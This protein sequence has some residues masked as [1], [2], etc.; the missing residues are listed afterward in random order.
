LH[1]ISVQV[2][3]NSIVK[4]K[5]NSIKISIN[6]LELSSNNLKYG[7]NWTLHHSV[8]SLM[9]KANEH[10]GSSFGCD[11]SQRHHVFEGSW[12]CSIPRPTQDH[13]AMVL[14]GSTKGSMESGAFD[15]NN[16]SFV[17]LRLTLSNYW[18][19]W[20]LQANLEPII[21]EKERSWLEIKSTC[22]KSESTWLFCATSHYGP[23]PSLI[24]VNLPCFFAWLS[25]FW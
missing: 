16:E 17:W 19:F 6:I 3:L 18:Q 8:V 5:F 10:L 25:I 22:N 13:W 9:G 23:Q 21:L 11:A 12:I 24:H 4:L 14:W 2:N 20:P 15:A 1:P 7:T